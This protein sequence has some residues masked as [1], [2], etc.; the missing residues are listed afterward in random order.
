MA[1][2]AGSDHDQRTR[3]STLRR[4]SSLPLEIAFTPAGT[5]IWIA[6]LAL[7]RGALLQASQAAVPTGSPTPTAPSLVRYQ[8][9]VEPSGSITLR[10]WP[11]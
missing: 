7:S 4:E 10:G 2:G 9:S 11:W 6:K 3:R 1:I 8:P 5:V